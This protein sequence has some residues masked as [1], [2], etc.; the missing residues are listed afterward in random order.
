MNLEANV[1]AVTKRIAQQFVTLGNKIAKLDLGNASA[2]NVTPS[3]TV[4]YSPA[5]N[6][7]RAGSAGDI[8]IADASG[9]QTTFT[10][11]AAGETIGNFN[12]VKVLSS[13]TAGSL[14]GYVGQ[15]NS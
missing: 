2:I 1:L 13:T 5:V 14:V 7:I 10:G 11:V 6:K 3:D 4:T 9:K 8:V 12:A 15:N